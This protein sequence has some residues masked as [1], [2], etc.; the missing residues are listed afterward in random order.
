MKG[1][2]LKIRPGYNPNSSSMGLLVLYIIIGGMGISNI[3]ASI[4][5]ASFLY[6]KRKKVIEKNRYEE[7][8]KA[9]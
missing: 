2:I 5:A 7:R 6:K 1:K 9:F 8:G 3:I 4:V